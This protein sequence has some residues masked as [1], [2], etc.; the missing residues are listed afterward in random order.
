MTRVKKQNHIATLL[1]KA[2]RRMVAR[3]TVALKPVGISIDMWTLLGILKEEPGQSMTSLADSLSLNLP[4]VTKLMDRMVSDNLAYRKPHH[5][6]RRRVLI[7]PTERGLNLFHE[8]EQIAASLEL[9]MEKNIG[10]LS[11]I[12][13][14]LE[15]LSRDG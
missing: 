12:K 5:S 6:D 9:A 14:G 11:P 2:H 7:F 10:D 13:E 15:N 1:A 3:L 8:A 4:T